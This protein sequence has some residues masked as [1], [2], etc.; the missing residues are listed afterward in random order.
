M[1][2]EE[3]P[4]ANFGYRL[5]VALH[6][7][8]L[9]FCT[10]VALT[11][12]PFA[13]DY[14]DTWVFSCMT[15]LTSVTV[16]YCVGY[17]WY[18]TRSS[19]SPSV[20]AWITFVTSWQLMILPWAWLVYVLL[21]ISAW[22]LPGRAAVVCSCSSLFLLSLA[23]LTMYWRYRNEI[24]AGRHIGLPIR[25]SSMGKPS[26]L[27][28][29]LELGWEDDQGRDPTAY[30]IVYVG[31]Y[32]MPDFWR[33][34]FVVVGLRT[35]TSPKSPSSSS[36]FVRAERDKRGWLDVLHGNLVQG[37][38]LSR[39]YEN[40]VS[41][42]HCITHYTI[43]PPSLTHTL[44]TFAQIVDQSRTY[45]ARYDLFAFNCRWFAASCYKA[46]TEGFT[47]HHLRMNIDKRD[48]TFQEAMAFVEQY[49]FLGHWEYG[50]LINYVVL[51]IT[52]VL[53]FYTNLAFLA[54][55][56]PS[57][58]IGGWALYYLSVIMERDSL[59]LGHSQTQDT[60]IGIRLAWQAIWVAV[61]MFF[62]G[63]VFL[64]L[65]FSSLLEIV[66]VQQI[67]RE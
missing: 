35:L 17:V 3:K 24:W 47:V 25:S 2:Y 15:I 34:Q 16:I 50:L 62:Y 48:S 36:L 41:G 31:L 30:H 61:V 43:N 23:P 27:D 64:L 14:T 57:I 55:F 56:V 54:C 42:S 60:R 51:I 7:I 32:E 40:L 18:H 6:A 66:Q 11:A 5:D 21:E 58:L 67:V 52:S 28:Q 65:S 46:V 20:M 10:G 26:P 63:L 13:F 29:I 38:R 37:F 45:S 39:H 4:R 8:L 12:C 19:Y 53:S 1:W 9:M 49:Y 44:L 22:A 59:R 33:H